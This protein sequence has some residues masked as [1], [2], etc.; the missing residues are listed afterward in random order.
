[1]NT[2]SLAR[3]QRVLQ[4]DALRMLRPVLYC[5]LAFL[6]LTLL[7]HA[8]LSGTGAAT[9]PSTSMVVFGIYLLGGGLLLTSLVF[10]DMHHPLEGHRYLMLPCSNFERF[11]SR[12][13]LTGPLLLLHVVLSFTAMDWVANQLTAAWMDVRDPAFSPF[14]P[15]ALVMIRA[16]LFA[17]VLVLT[18]AIFFRSLALPRTVLFLLVAGAG[19]L[20]VVHLAD[21]I[22]Y[23][24]HFSWTR[25]GPLR[26]LGFELLPL[27]AAAWMNV[28][29]ALGFTLWMLRIAYHGLCTHEVQDGL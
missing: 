3:F 20:A 19:L 13:L 14:A 5:T 29:A 26:P 18:G 23:W 25:W 16:Y 22:F 28:V 27:F 10:H 1:L 12:Y 24:D 17:Q 2:I 11:L 4:N 21:R 15:P 9:Q 7:L 6:A 8:T